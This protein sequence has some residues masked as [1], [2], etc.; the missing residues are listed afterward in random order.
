M[1]WE[2]IAAIGQVLGSLAVF[3]TL[4]YLSVQVRHARGEVRRSVTQSRA[5]GAR[6]LAMNHA[7]NQRLTSTFLK[8]NARLGGPVNP[9]VTTLMEQSGLTAEEA[10]GLWWEQLAFWQNR[11][12]AIPYIGEMTTGQRIHLDTV[13]R[14][15]YGRTPV[16][17][18]WYETVKPQMDPDAVRYVDNLLAQPG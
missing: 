13:L 11:V 12:Q 15:Q 6:E 1:N 8:A 10:N 18:L 5:E 16:P 17:R 9:F 3:I 2:A 14:T 4:V 7:N